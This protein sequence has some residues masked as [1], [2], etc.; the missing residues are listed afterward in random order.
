MLPVP[1][2]GLVNGWLLVVVFYAVFGALLLLFPRPV[3][4][5]LYDRTGQRLSSLRV[6]GLVAF[7]VWLLL[8]VITPIRIR[9]AAFLVGFALYVSGFAGFVAA[10]F[11]FAATPGHRPIVTGLYRVS[12][13]PQNFALWLSFLGISI[14]MGSWLA[15]FLV[16]IGFVSVHYT[17]VLPEERAC[18][19]AYGASYREYMDRVPRYFLFF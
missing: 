2:L 16:S 4:A 10:L 14:A 15:I 1:Q 18:L 9:D 8:T 7:A 11:T 3:V 19:Q 13:H 17:K 12:R 6:F 5:R